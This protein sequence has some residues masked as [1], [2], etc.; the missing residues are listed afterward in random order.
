MR[1][2][3][4]KYVKDDPL[5]FTLRQLQGFIFAPR[6]W[7][8]LLTV[9]LILGLTG[10]FDTFEQMALLPRLGYWLAVALATFLA[11]Y[12]ATALTLRYLF[13]DR[14]SRPVREA[15][16]GFV[17]GVPITAIVL[18]LN[19]A[20]LGTPAGSAADVLAFYVECSLIAGGI[21]LLFGLI[22][23]PQRPEAA[24]TGEPGAAAEAERPRLLSRLPAHLRGELWYMSMQDHYV[25]VRTGKGNALVLMRFADAIAE[26]APT[27]GLQI[28]R[29]HWVALGAVKGAL[30]RDGRAYLRMADGAELPVSRGFR[31]EAKAA[32]LL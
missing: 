32:G 30:R 29:S 13:G 20:L 18:L 2:R 24:Q 12:T 15:V 21:S 28:H 19:H 8:I 9:G 23:R 11:G 14:G 27:A 6:F 10:P 25:D 5:Q 22:D 16:S 1:E 17:A 7:G 4:A 31:A 3:T 26:T